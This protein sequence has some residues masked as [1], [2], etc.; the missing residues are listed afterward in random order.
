MRLQVVTRLRSLLAPAKISA[1]DK[2]K[3][4]LEVTTSLWNL[5][6]ARDSVAPEDI[7]VIEAF[8]VNLYSSIKLC[9]SWR[10]TRLI[11]ADRCLEA[12]T[13][14]HPERLPLSNT[15]SKSFSRLATSSGG[16]P[17][18]SF[19]SNPKDWGWVETDNGWVPHWIHIP[20]AAVAM[21]NDIKSCNWGVKCEGICGSFWK[22][23][24][25]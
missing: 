15:S 6:E 17:W 24:Y 11:F 12:L 20:K 16:S 2:W 7:K 19:R 8:I 13:Y 21:K 10:L 18:W 22:G 9:P 5:M 14:C 23:L 1:Y 3:N 4:H 25:Y